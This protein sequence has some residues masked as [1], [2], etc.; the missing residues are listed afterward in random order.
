MHA[1]LFVHFR[2]AYSFIKELCLSIIRIIFI[3]LHHIDPFSL[4]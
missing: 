4:A 3:L 2:I 1:Y